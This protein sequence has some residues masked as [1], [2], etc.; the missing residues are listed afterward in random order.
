VGKHDRPW[1]ERPIFGKIRYMSF[2]STSKK[3]DSKSYIRQMEELKWQSATGM[4]C[5]PTLG[6]RLLA[7]G[8]VAAQI[9]RAA[10]QCGKIAVRQ[11]NLRR[12]Q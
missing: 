2:N 11:K 12:P 6:M 9:S 1:F 4:Y 8:D 10:L 7:S 3:F 5:A